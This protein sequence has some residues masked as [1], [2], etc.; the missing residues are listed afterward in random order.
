MKRILACAF[1]M[2]AMNGAASATETVNALLRDYSGGG[3]ESFSAR[4]GEQLWLQEQAGNDGKT[5]S[6]TSC[7]T[8][9]PRQPGRHAVTGKAI[10]PLA[11]SVNPARLTERR[12]I[13]KWLVRNCKC[14][15]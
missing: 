8:T 11:P 12:K 4:Q 7:H 6:C 14:L 15:R 3:S 5:R 9:D 1:C 10:G 2:L 13:E